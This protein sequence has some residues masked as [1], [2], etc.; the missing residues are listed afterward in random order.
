MTRVI[1]CGS[2]SAADL[3]MLVEAGV[4]GVGLITEVWQELGC[5]LTRE[6]A[7]Q[8]AQLLPPLVVS[9]L[10]ITEGKL[11][12][13][14][15]MAEA[16]RPDVLQ[17]HGPSPPRDI[18]RLAANLEA[19]VVKALLVDKEG[20]LIEGGKP[21]E[22]AKEY[23]QAGA[24]AIVFDSI[25]PGKVGATGEMSSLELAR[26]IR[27]RIWPAPLILAGGLSP[28][29]VAEAIQLVRPYAVDVL[30]GVL[31]NGCLDPLK[32]TQFIGEVHRADSQ[33]RAPIAR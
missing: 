3:G 25:R 1:V 27:D 26:T 20:K 5:K 8:F 7:R 4:N 12:E 19:K 22:V 13:V 6:E 11:D 31:S 9:V 33:A 23:I 10:I 30:S 2:R 32:V 17:L 29:N 24:S 28:S 15:R 18:E 14:F 16:V 21:E